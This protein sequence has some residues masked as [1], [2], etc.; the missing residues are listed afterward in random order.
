MART[1]PAELGDDGDQG[2]RRAVSS[3][4]HEAVPA[5]TGAGWDVTVTVD[6]L[7]VHVTLKA[8][9]VITSEVATRMIA[10][11]DRRRTTVGH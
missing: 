10:S 7:E 9:S 3:L 5:P 6:G 2:F 1:T 4:G 11:T 8:G